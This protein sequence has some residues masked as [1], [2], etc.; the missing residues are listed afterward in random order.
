VVVSRGSGLCHTI[1]SSAV[2]FCLQFGA[3]GL[4]YWCS[5]SVLYQKAHTLQLNLAV[6]YASRMC[7]SVEIPVGN[8]KCRGNS[9]K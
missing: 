5:F 7:L 4:T 6:L 3:F 8:W 9:H 1:L 2:Y